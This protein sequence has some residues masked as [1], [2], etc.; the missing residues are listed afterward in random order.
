MRG[1]TPSNKISTKKGAPLDKK[2]PLPLRSQSAW[3]KVLLFKK[4]GGAVSGDTQ[5][6]QPVRIYPV[7][8]YDSEKN[9]M[10]QVIQC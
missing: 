9:V 10:F 4:E 3:M 2:G 8:H 1:H 7:R 5:R 6:S